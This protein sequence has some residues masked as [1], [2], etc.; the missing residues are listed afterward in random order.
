[1]NSSFRLSPLDAI[2]PLAFSINRSRADLV[3]VVCIDN[4]GLL[5]PCEFYPRLRGKT[6][7]TMWFSFAR[8]WGASAVMFACRPQ[9]TAK[10]P[11]TVDLQLAQQLIDYGREI[12]IPTLELLLIGDNHFRV[13]S[14][15]IE[16][17]GPARLI[18][19]HRHAVARKI[20]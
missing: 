10:F 14:Q 16:G 8:R 1:M 11:G 4:R 18:P 13:M 17:F 9:D 2:E 15:T 5:G 6:L 7:P 19:S 12:E 3:A 20:S